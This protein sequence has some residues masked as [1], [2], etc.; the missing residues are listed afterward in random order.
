[1]RSSCA[2]TSSSEVGVRLGA[3]LMAALGGMALGGWTSGAIFDLTGV[4]SGGARQRHCLEP[5]QPDD[6]VVA[7]A[8]DELAAGAPIANKLGE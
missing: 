6:R 4:V 5:P 7:L 8:A 2:S 3:V 1:M